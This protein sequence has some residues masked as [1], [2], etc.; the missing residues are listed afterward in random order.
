[1]NL[2]IVL[3][4]IMVLFILLI[5]YGKI[6]FYVTYHKMNQNNT[7]KLSIIL[8]NYIKLY[9]KEFHVVDKDLVK[10]VFSGNKK[11]GKH[12]IKEKKNNI[13]ENMIDIKKRNKKSAKINLK[14]FHCKKLD[15][16]ICI[17][18]SNSAVTALLYG[19]LSSI[20][21]AFL[22]YLHKVITFDTIPKGRICPMFTTQQEEIRVSC[23]FT[24]SIGNIIYMLRS[25][26]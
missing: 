25:L 3:S 1:M 11:C 7:L 17:G 15:Y 22:A 19:V 24:L 5:F 14:Y 18:F 6:Y 13:L 23:I 20:K 21:G 4:I 10:E 12:H 16:L 8:F 26:L 9:H 2:L